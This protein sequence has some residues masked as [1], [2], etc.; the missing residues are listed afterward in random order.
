MP[1][2]C[3]DHF[4]NIAE[5]LANQLPN[6]LKNPSDYLQNRKENSFIFLPATPDEIENVIKELKDNGT[7]I[8]K[9][10]NE[11]LKYVNDVLSPILAH[12]LNICTQ[13]YFPKN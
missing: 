10:S 2:K 12:I 4:T 13:G 1:I 8:N 9:I 6:S 5:T 3:V 7:G 11:V